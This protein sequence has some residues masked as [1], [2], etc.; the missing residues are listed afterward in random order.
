VIAGQHQAP[1]CSRQQHQPRPFWI[2]GAHLALPMIIGSASVDRGKIGY[3]QVWLIFPRSRK[4]SAGG[5]GAE[6]TVPTVRMGLMGT[7][8]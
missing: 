6:R 2:G 3:S 4:L 5:C 8:G 1:D 7:A